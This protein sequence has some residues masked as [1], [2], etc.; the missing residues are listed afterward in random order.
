MT[1]EGAQFAQTTDHVVNFPSNG[2]PL[3]PHGAPIGPPRVPEPVFGPGGTPVM[4]RR[5]F[6]NRGPVCDYCE[7]EN[8]IGLGHTQFSGAAMDWLN[9]QNPWVAGAV[10]LGGSLLTGTLLAGGSIWILR[11]V[12]HREMKLEGRR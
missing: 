6:P 3:A 2:Q 12:G 7:P 5:R 1:L 10:I 11:R 9:R 4:Y 8:F